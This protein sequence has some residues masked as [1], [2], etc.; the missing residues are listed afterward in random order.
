MKLMAD[1]LSS[2]VNRVR[3]ELCELVYPA[4][5]ALSSRTVVHL[6]SVGT[7]GQLATGSI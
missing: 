6:R 1:G 4:P 3:Q 2:K 7:Y 5:L